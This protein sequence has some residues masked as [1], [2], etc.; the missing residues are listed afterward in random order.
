MWPFDLP[1]REALRLPGETAVTWAV[2]DADWYR[3]SYPDDLKTISDQ[4]D[5]A[6]LAYYLDAGQRLGH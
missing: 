3:A 2:F 5:A 6:M 1:V 4:S